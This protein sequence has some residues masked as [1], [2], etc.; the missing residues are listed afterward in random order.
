MDTLILT[1]GLAFDELPIVRISASNQM[2][3]GAWSQSN[4]SGAKLRQR[5]L[6]MLTVSKDE[7]LSTESTLTI[8]WPALESSLDTGNSEILS[9]EV[10]WDANT[11][12]TNILLHDD[13][14]LT[15]LVERLEPGETY[16]FKVRARNIYGYG[17]F[18]DLSYL[19]PHAE[20][21]TMDA[22]S[23]TLVYPTV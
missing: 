4:S 17:P 2:G 9:Y 3:Q 16:Q 5:P 18:S 22:P 7:S 20:P 23:T 21:A 1:Y 10:Y 8:N 15:H 13:I 6:K 11:A 19:I 12:T 14:L